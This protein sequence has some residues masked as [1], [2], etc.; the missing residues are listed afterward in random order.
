MYWELYILSLDCRLERSII[1][2]LHPMVIDRW[3]QDEVQNLL[4]IVSRDHSVMVVEDMW[5]PV[6]KTP[7]YRTGDVLVV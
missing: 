4:L 6:Q 2:F 7:F 5:L 1:L 3:V